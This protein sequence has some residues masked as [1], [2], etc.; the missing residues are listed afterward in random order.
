MND[1]QFQN[2]DT[3]PNPNPTQG[4]SFT[5]NPNF[6]PNFNSNCNPN[7]PYSNWQQPINDGKGFSVAAVVFGIAGIMLGWFP[8]L[9]IIVLVCSI[10]GIV[11]GVKGRKMSL[12][13][14]GISSGLATAGLILGIIGLCFTVLGL[15]CSFAIC[16]AIIYAAS[17]VEAAALMIALF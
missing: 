3:N 9:N 4:P 15:L 11:F 10:L 2:N 5:P 13:A 17:E 1:Q 14:N 8:V 6:N 7:N 16:S 12:A